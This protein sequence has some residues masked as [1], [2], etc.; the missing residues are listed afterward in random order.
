MTQW[1]I[2]RIDIAVSV[3][4]IISAIEV[5]DIAV[6]TAVMI[7]LCAFNLAVAASMHT[8]GFWYHHGF[9]RE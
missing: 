8:Q 7:S 6:F 2:P 9:G 5:G 4:A 1:W 3:V